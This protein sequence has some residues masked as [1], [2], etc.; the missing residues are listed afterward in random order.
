M[1]FAGTV[2]RRTT[3]IAWVVAATSCQSATTAPTCV[4][5]IDLELS[6]DQIFIGDT[7]TAT[8]SHSVDL[9]L[10][11]LD[12]MTTGPISLEEAQ[13]TSATFTA[14]A[15]GTGMITVRNREGDLGVLSVEVEAREGGKPPR[16]SDPA[17]PRI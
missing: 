13:G 1:M 9:C 6:S 2:V 14:N 10:V 8:A 4:G 3:L 5:T 11:D 16:A 12:W 15:E 7:F 17:L